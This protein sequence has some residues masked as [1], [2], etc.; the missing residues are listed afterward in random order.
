MTLLHGTCAIISTRSYQ[1]DAYHSG[2]QTHTFILHK[3]TTSQ[4]IHLP[5]WVSK[6]L[7]TTHHI[8]PR[9]IHPAAR[10]PS[11]PIPPP[12]QPLTQLPTTYPSQKPM[13]SHNPKP[14]P[15]L[16]IETRLPLQMRVLRIPHRDPQVSLYP[17]VSSQERAAEGILLW[18]L[19]LVVGLGSIRGI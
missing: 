14:P 12:A 1:S 10:H 7:L 19:L 2:S 16:F 13:L 3:H 8:T 6:K 17:A 9:D 4:T 5:H 11:K 18:L 15:P